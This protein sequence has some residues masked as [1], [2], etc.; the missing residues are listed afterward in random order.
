MATPEYL[1][2]GAVTFKSD[3]YCLGIII[4]QIVTGRN[5]KDCS[6]TVGVRLICL[7]TCI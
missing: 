7:T 4:M 1:D 2:G 5:R 6:N 3:I